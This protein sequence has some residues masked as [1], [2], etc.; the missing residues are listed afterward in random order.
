MKSAVT[1]SLVR[2]AAGGPF[3]FWHDL[4]G[5][6]REAAALGFDAVEIFPPAPE[7]V[8]SAD[9]GD[10]LG[11]YGLKLA[12][13]GTGAGWV[14]HRLTLTSPDAAIRQQAKNYIR[15]IID[16]GGRFGAPAIIGSMQGR[17]ADAIDRPAALSF[18]AEAL[19]E[20]ALSQ[21][22]PLRPTVFSPRLDCMSHLLA[23]D[24]LQ[25]FQ[26]A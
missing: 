6:M 25:K 23:A 12:A 26:S 24:S 8:N 18:L 16:A 7:V 10:L 5:S 11:K 14:K 21:G 9:V 4:E 1:I 15:S 22:S 2:E 3:V 20:L 17:W 13:V 19:N